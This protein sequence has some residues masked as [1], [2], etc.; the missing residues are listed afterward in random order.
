MHE[1]DIAFMDICLDGEPNVATVLLK[2][3]Y[4]FETIAPDLEQISMGSGP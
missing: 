4:F 2:D 1:L 3:G